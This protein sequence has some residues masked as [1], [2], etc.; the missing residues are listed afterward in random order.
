[1]PEKPKYHVIH[2]GHKGA[3][4]EFGAA[5]TRWNVPETTLSFEGHQ[6]ERAK[7]VEMLDEEALAKGSVSME[8]VFQEMGRRFH[9]GKGIRRVIQS[10]Y[11]L[12]TR[13]HDLFAIGWIQ[14][15]LT[16]KGGTGWAVELA[17]IFNRHVNVYD[18]E[19]NAW[20]VWQNHSWQPS[21]P[22]LPNSPFS[23]T[24]TRNLDENGRNAIEDLFKRSLG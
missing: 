8:F 17:K 21:E 2:G 14:E 5:A 6:M 24:G 1:M 23:A 12:V 3:E 16:V 15:D 4:S 18:Q 11:H 19:K 10:M 7:N 13:T 20:F 9:R 22:T